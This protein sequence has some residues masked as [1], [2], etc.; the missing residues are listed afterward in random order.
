MPIISQYYFI[1]FNNTLQWKLGIVRG[2]PNPGGISKGYEGVGV[3]VYSF[4]ASSYPIPME[5][6]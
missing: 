6:M 3:G 2:M 5:G 1:N 4:I